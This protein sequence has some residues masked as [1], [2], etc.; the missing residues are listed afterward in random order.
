M[1]PVEPTLNRLRATGP[2]DH[3]DRHI[4]DAECEHPQHVA[5]AHEPEQGRPMPRCDGRQAHNACEALS[6]APGDRLIAISTA[7]RDGR[8]ELAVGDNG[9]GLTADVAARLFEPFVTTKPDGLGVG[10]AI[11][12]SIAERHGG[13][14]TAV[15]APGGGLVMTLSLPI[16]QD[17]E[18]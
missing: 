14:L 13:R 17:L 9:P 10:L 1:A 4:E 18:S 3:R 16:A 8:V 2:A 7:E 6:A 5:T 11:C 12:R 15:P